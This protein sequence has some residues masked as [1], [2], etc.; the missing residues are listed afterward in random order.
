ML[1]YLKDQI[2]H[3]GLLFA[4]SAINDTTIADH[5]NT[6]KD[7]NFWVVKYLVSPSKCLKL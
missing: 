1:P 6:E 2:I 3:G 7:E 5:F 4:K